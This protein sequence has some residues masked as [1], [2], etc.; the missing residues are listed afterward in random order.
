MDS[1]STLILFSSTIAM[2]LWGIHRT[3]SLQSAKWEIE[4][5]ASQITDLGEEPK[6][7]FTKP[8]FRHR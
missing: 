6:R 2:L 4:E 7:V 5:L 3:L 8:R 1:I